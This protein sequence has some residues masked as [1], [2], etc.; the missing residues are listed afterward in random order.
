MEEKMKKKKTPKRNF[1]AKELLCSGKFAMRIIRNKKAYTRKV[2]F[3]KCSEI[4]SSEHFLRH[5]LY[6]NF[7]KLPIRFS[8]HT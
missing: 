4:N 8:F 3:K 1:I 6:V 7:K 2:K 5:L